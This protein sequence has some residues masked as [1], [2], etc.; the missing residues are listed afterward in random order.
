MTQLEKMKMQLANLRRNKQRAR[1]RGDPN[2]F[3]ISA[4]HK[5]KAKEIKKMEAEK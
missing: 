5:A 3:R 2:F 1:R 4:D